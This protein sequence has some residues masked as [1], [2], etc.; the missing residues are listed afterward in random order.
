MSQTSPRLALPYI[1]PA[2]AQKHVTHN[3]AIQRLDAAVQLVLSG[4]AV[5]DPP[6]GPG[7]GD[8]YAL[9]AAP[10]GDWTG[11]GGQLAIWQGDGWYFWPPS[12]GGAPGYWRPIRLMC[13]GR[14][15]GAWRGAIWVR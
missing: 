9:G 15:R 7:V 2:Q 5:L 12:R 1:Q 8:V 3:E 4:L 6:A 14:A 10:T 13:S 11:Q